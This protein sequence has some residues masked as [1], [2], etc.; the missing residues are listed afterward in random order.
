MRIQPTITFEQYVATHGA[1]LAAKPSPGAKRSWRYYLTLAIVCLAF[2][3]AVQFPP[4]RIPALTLFGAVVLYGAVGK[5][6]VK[7]SRD[8]YMRRFYAEEQAMLNDQILTIDES[9]ISTVRANG[10]VTSHHCW[11]AFIYWIEM[12]DAMVFLPTP[13]TFIRVPLGELTAAEVHAGMECCP[14]HET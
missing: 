7:R 1:V 13:N 9:G 6:L 12:P 8:R 10:D 3:I 5:A 2:G 4:T 11:N 14:P